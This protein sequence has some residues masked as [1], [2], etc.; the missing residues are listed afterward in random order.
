MKRSL[1]TKPLILRTYAV[2]SRTK[3]ASTNE[4]GKVMLGKDNPSCTYN[5]IYASMCDHLPWVLDLLDTPP[6]TFIQLYEYSVLRTLKYKQIFLKST[7]YKKLKSFQFFY[8][9]F[10]R[11][12]LVPKDGDFTFIDVRMKASMKNILYKVLVILDSS[13]NVSSAACTCPAGSGLGGFG[14]CN[15]VGGV[16]FAL[17][18]F[19]RK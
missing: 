18:D 10:I 9:G 6:Y 13:G 5:E 2:F 19:N 16:L 7:G 3:R 17:E 15:R 11:K 8:E 4:A 1:V 14:N 12:F